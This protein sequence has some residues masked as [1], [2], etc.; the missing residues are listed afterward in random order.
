[1][2]L[3]TVVYAQDLFS[4]GCKDLYSLA[5]AL[6]YDFKAEEQDEEEEREGAV[7]CGMSFPTVR[8]PELGRGLDVLHGNLKEWDANSSPEACT[9][10]GLLSGNFPAP[11][12]TPAPGRRKRRRAKSCKN[13]EEV[14]NQ[15]MTHIAVERNR[16]KQMNEYLAVLRSLMP[17]S[18]V[19]RG[20][21]ASIIGGAIN[22]VKE[23]EQLLQSMEAHKRTTQQ[24]NASCSPPFADFFTYPQYSSRA[25]NCN[26]S[27]ETSAENHSAIP[28]IEVNMVESHANLKVLTRRRPKQLL[29]MIAGFQNL[30]L[31]ILHLNV[32][33][34]DQMVLYSFSVKV[35]DNCTLTSVDEIATAVKQMVGRIQGEG[36]LS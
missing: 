23:L 20:D 28:E 19:Q 13:K 18:Y 12:T 29:Q 14:E 1:M 9:P 10:D 5:A 17:P 34:T 16:R 35:E 2:A 8:N 11:E 3:E 30:Y 33:T 6:S 36:S 21:Q 31:T 26:P 32:T 24:L 27:S 25:N 15:R 7:E 22:F 4:Y